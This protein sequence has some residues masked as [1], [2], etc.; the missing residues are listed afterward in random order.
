MNW[1]FFWGLTIVGIGLLLVIL[2][3]RR[4]IQAIKRAG[5]SL[6]EEVSE[7]I[8]SAALS[9]VGGRRIPCAYS[10]EATDGPP[11]WLLQVESHGTDDPNPSLFLYPRTENP[12]CEAILAHRGAR[13]VPGFLRRHGD[14]LWARLE[15]AA[16]DLQSAVA[17]SGWFLYI[18]PADSP[19]PAIV[20]RLARVARAVPPKAVI[21]IGLHGRFFGLWTWGTA[22]PLLSIGPRA[23]EAF[24]ASNVN[25]TRSGL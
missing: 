4:R 23:R 18:D 22:V 20:E 1:S 13:W 7:E 14:G 25:Q 11:T 6:R 8:R 15:P 2:V 21:G 19:P 5:F 17:D 9:L 10:Q 3:V 16:A 24:G 12:A